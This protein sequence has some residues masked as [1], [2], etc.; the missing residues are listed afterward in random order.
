MV[1][2]DRTTTNFTCCSSTNNRG[3]ATLAAERTYFREATGETRPGNPEWIDCSRVSCTPQTLAN[4]LPQPRCKYFIE[5][6][7]IEIVFIL[8]E[9]QSF[10][11]WTN[12]STRAFDSRNSLKASLAA[13]AISISDDFENSWEL[14]LQI[15]AD[16]EF[17]KKRRKRAQFGR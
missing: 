3:C 2:G 13:F 14:A 17:R 11:S 6:D 1:D 4:I 12:G 15:R 16:N 9:C 8:R 10:E 7:A 5:F